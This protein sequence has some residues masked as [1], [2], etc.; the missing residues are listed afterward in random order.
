ME[1]GIKLDK[2]DMWKVSKDDTHEA[3]L[4]LIDPEDVYTA[5]VRFDGC[6]HLYRY[7]EKGELDYYIHICDLDG[8]ILRLQALKTEA[9]KHFGKDWPG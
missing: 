2:L 1:A 5:S 8:M 9:L 3:M 4:E 6:V 7:E